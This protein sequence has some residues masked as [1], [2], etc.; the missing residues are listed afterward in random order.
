MRAGVLRLAARLEQPDLEHL[1]RV[2]P[3]V[4]GGIDVQPLVALEPDEP[5][6]ERRGQHLGELG[7]ADAGL[8]FEQQRPTE[9]ER[10]EDGR[11]ERPVGDVVATAEVLGQRIDRAGA[12][13]AV[14]AVAGGRLEG[15]VIASDATRS[16][17]CPS[18]PGPT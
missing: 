7:L 10:E 12:G 1:A 17:G 6:A 13:W 3:L 2:V 18:E 16:G 8:A 15:S 9:L 11:R 4:D 5:R 14:V